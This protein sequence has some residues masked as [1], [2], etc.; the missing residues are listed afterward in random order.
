[1]VVLRIEHPVQ[2]FDRWK[3]TFDADP[4]DR[5]GSGVR[6]HVVYRP[7]GDSGRVAVD[8]SFDSAEAAEAMAGRITSVTTPD[9]GRH[10]RYGEVF[11]AYRQLYPQLRGVFGALDRLAG[12]QQ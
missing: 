4:L 10:A 8:L 9:A 2:D 6:R 11:A 5:A 1:M 7:A 3:E 12:A